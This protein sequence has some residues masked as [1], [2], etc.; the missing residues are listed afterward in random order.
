MQEERRQPT[1]QTGEESWLSCGHRAGLS[2]DSGRKKD[3]GQAAVHTRQHP[4]P[5]AQHLHQAEECV[6][7]QTAVPV[8]LHQQTQKLFRPPRH[9]TV[10]QLPVKA[11]RTIDNRQF[12]SHV[13][14]TL[15]FIFYS[16]FI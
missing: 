14:I 2:G 12:L 5:S 8:Q 10:Q 16:I 3:P 11:G 1:G 13:Y 15:Y 7:W 4:P 6:Q 9:Q